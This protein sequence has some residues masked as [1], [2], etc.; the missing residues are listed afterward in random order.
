MKTKPTEIVYVEG[1]P[2]DVALSF[3]YIQSLNVV[4][5]FMDKGDL[6]RSGRVLNYEGAL[7]R[8]DFDAI[9]KIFCSDQFHESKKDKEKF[10]ARLRLALKEE[11]PLTNTW[12]ETQTITPPPKRAPR[13]D[14]FGR[15]FRLYDVINQESY[16]ETK[17]H[18]GKVDFQASDNFIGELEKIIGTHGMPD[19]A[20]SAKSLVLKEAENEGDFYTIGEYLKFGKSDHADI[21]VFLDKEPKGIIQFIPDEEKES[22]YR[23]AHSEEYCPTNIKVDVDGKIIT[24][25]RNMWC[26][27]QENMTLWSLDKKI[28]KEILNEVNTYRFISGC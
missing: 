13:K 5:S 28:R 7:E 16:E 4:E 6:Y 15:L 27:S 12:Y 21:T 3:D 22:S 2:K 11:Q 8:G 26:I 20:N 23:G 19:S 18:V 17:T 25:E 1:W 14:L 10:L 9:N 24:A